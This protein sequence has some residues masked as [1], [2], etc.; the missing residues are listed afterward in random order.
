M[1]GVSFLK[2]YRMREQIKYYQGYYVK[3]ME[4][5]ILE[6]GYQNHQYILK[7]AKNTWDGELQLLVLTYAAKFQHT[8]HI[9]DEEG[10]K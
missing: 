4:T 7:R 3:N 9:Y 5:V 2:L 10:A 8:T 1:Q 6:K